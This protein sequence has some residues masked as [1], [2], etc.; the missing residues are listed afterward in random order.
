LQVSCRPL[1]AQPANVRRKLLA[2]FPRDSPAL[3]FTNERA[4]ERRALVGNLSLFSHIHIG[5]HPSRQPTNQPASQPST[6]SLSFGILHPKVRVAL[7][8][9]YAEFLIPISCICHQTKMS[10]FLISHH[11]KDLTICGVTLCAAAREGTRVY[12]PRAVNNVGC[13][14][15]QRITYHPLYH[16]RRR[17]RGEIVICD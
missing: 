15:Y 11:L 1:F 17:R 10:N 16:K 13:R 5:T 6:L 8:F 7:S 14:Q 4:R 9:I 12:T 2:V 3:I